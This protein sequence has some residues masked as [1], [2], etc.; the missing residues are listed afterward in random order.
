MLNA[1][2]P[3]VTGF[4]DVYYYV[5]DMERALE[6]YADLLGLEVLE[7]EEFW[8]SLAAPGSSGQLGLHWTGGDPVPRSGR[9]EHG[10]HAGATLTLAVA[11]IGDAI[12][13]LREGGIAILGDVQREDWGA[14]VDIADPDGNILLLMESAD[15]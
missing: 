7:R 9:G 4:A 5:A 8:C 12:A 11:D 10:A 2:T 1:T 15:A 3:L 13:R 6:F 14:A